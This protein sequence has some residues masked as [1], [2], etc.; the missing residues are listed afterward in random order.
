MTSTVD[1]FLDLAALAQYAGLCKRTLRY[2]MANPARP[3]PHYRVGGKILVK[4]SEFDGWMS[5]FKSAE[6]PWVDT[7]V[8]EMLKGF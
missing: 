6:G 1:A 3:L 7:V 5:Q 2:H 4:R 8:T